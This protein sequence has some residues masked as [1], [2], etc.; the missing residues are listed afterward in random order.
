MARLKINRTTQARAL[1]E[2]PVIRA[3]FVVVS[4]AEI[5]SIVHNL[6]SRVRQ[7]RLGKEQRAGFKPKKNGQKR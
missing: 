1:K 3:L 5:E 4:E 7:G 2:S 6:K